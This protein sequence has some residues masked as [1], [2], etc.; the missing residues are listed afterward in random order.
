M[1]KLKP[2]NV[3]LKSEVQRNRIIRLRPMTEDDWDILV[4]WNND[5]EVL[6]YSEGD[7]VS[8]YTREQVQIIYRTVSQKAFCFIVENNGI[9]VGECYLQKMNL[10]R[11]LSKYPKLDCR[12]IDIM[13]GEKN[14]WG[15]GIGTEV[16]RL[17]TD[18]G[19]QKQGADMIFGCDIGDHNIRSLSMFQK[20]GYR[21][22]LKIKEDT[23]KKS[24]Y[25][26]DLGLSKANYHRKEPNA[27]SKRAP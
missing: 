20:L 8:A 27:D 21:R 22:I 6:F 10:D 14:Y 18:F 11:I 12:R 15:L 24:N 3:I 5:P 16:I 25:R 7:D 9:P 26:Y 19:F 17:L 1:I 2:H 23:G 13:I 4:V